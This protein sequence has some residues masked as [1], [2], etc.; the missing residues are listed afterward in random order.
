[1]SIKEEPTIID[2]CKRDLDEKNYDYI[3]FNETDFNDLE[4]RELFNNTFRSTLIGKSDIYIFIET[5]D[6]HKDLKQKF[7]INVKE[8]INIFDNYITHLGTESKIL[9]NNNRK[10][11]YKGFLLGYKKNFIIENRTDYQGPYELLFSVA[12]EEEKVQHLIYRNN[13]NVSREGIVEYRNLVLKIVN[14]EIYIP[15]QMEI[16][17]PN[18][19]DPLNIEQLSYVA[20]FVNYKE[21]FENLEQVSPIYKNLIETFNY[22]PISYEIFRDIRKLSE[23]K[24]IHVYEDDK[25]PEFNKEEKKFMRK[26]G[27]NICNW[28]E[29]N[30]LEWLK[31]KKTKSE[32][33]NI[34]KNICLTK[35]N[36]KELMK[37]GK[38]EDLM[39]LEDITSLGPFCFDT[40]L[41]LGGIAFT[42]INIPDTV[43]SIGQGCFEL[44]TSLQQIEIPQS[45]TRL[46]D[47]VFTNCSLLSNIKLHENIYSIGRY[48][49]DRC[50]NLNK[51]ELPINLTS[52][53]EF[54]FKDCT[55]LSDIRIPLNIKFIGQGCFSKCKFE[56]F[57][58]PTA[59]EIIKDSTFLNNKYLIDMIIPPTVVELENNCFYGC[60]SLRKLMIPDSITRLGDRCFSKCISFRILRFTNKNLILGNE[61]FANCENVEY[62]DLDD[63][64][65]ELPNECF[66][67]CIKLKDI[68][69]TRKDQEGTIKIVNNQIERFGNSCFS[70]CN[71]LVSVKLPVN[72]KYIGDSCFK[73]C[74]NLV[75][76]KIPNT[77]TYIGPK[78]FENCV[79]L[80]DISNIEPEFRKERLITFANIF[81][82]CKEL[83]EK[84]I[85]KFMEENKVRKDND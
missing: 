29:I 42:A 16:E 80:I 58:Y 40:V 32:Q 48:C 15:K 19:A 68:V 7:L 55:E 37:K 36:R 47:Y 51:I 79:N 74:Q 34:Y 52:L 13:F 18:H 46:E 59:L 83:D 10:L 8:R 84:T 45:I 35:E 54:C 43:T 22:N 41:S 39:K 6:I 27:I 78:C 69:F 20:K 25:I 64:V 38:Y 77:V 67:K 73:E 23:L 11:I 82:G 33:K 14:L 85:E 21:D 49:F 56:K 24:T 30:Y 12:Y 2:Y 61:C 1:M 26:N 28:Q 44:C 75:S 9:D 53:G 5:K 71:S 31:I 81:K 60:V 66:K 57:Y 3:Q 17:E 72:L 65:K 62:Y 76:I 63:S 50:G 4:K 70:Y